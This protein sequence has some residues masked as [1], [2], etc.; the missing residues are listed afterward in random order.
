[1]SLTFS[2]Y[3]TAL[4]ELTNI[5][6]TETFFQDI[7]PDCIDYSEQRCYRE[8]NL[9]ST[10][11]RDASQ[12]LAP[13]SRNFVLPNAQGNFVVVN[14]INAITPAGT[15]PSGGTRNALLPV[16]LDYLD[17][18]WP[19]SDAT[20]TGLPTAFAMV[21]QTSIVVGPWPDQAY[22]MEVVGTQ[23]PL[24]LSASNTVTFLS[25]SLPD[26]FLAASMVFMSGAMRNFG[27]QADDAPMAASW[28][29]QYDKLFASAG[30]EE[31]RK[32]YQAQAW[33]NQVTNPLTQR[34]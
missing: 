6:S 19:S 5:A 9:L 28:Q 1:M 31:L 27:S 3:V 17:N 13:G 30:M 4:S 23:R 25:D 11:V 21:T 16:S 14:R 24:P 20:Y 8:L 34:S 12:A 10:V 2:S 18:V 32:K 26:L 29:S 33:Q 15:Q 7:L 22:T